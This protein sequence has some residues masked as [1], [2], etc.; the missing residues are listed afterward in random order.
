MGSQTRSRQRSDKDLEEG[1]VTVIKLT[2]LRIFK[3]SLKHLVKTLS[4]GATGNI[5]TPTGLLGD[6]GGW[7]SSM[8]SSPEESMYRGS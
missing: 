5:V 1:T 3:S 2:S 7:I 4:E 8:S 6:G